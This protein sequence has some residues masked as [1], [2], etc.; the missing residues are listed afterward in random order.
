MESLG[1]ICYLSGNEGPLT[2]NFPVALIYIEKTFLSVNP[3]SCFLY[4]TPG[5]GFSGKGRR[6]EFFG[7]GRSVGQYLAGY[8]NPFRLMAHLPPLKLN[9]SQPLI[10]YIPSNLITSSPLYQKLP[11]SFFLHILFF[12]FMCA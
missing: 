4:H 10:V 2:P 6:A 11:I 8:G 1:Y 12:F 9:Y 7:S 3:F 5:S